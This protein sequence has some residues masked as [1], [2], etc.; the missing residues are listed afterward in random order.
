MKV[1][2]LRVII[3]IAV[4]LVTYFAL[5]DVGLDGVLEFL[6]IIKLGWWWCMIT[7]LLT[8]A[9]FSPGALQMLKTAKAG[10]QKRV[11]PVIVQ[12]IQ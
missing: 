1:L 8:A 9:R 2:L 11:T 7:K 3:V 12:P 5:I 6:K 4:V 10:M